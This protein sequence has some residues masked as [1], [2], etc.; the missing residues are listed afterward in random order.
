VA[1]ADESDASFMHLQPM[2]A[3]VTNIEATIT[4]ATLRRRLREACKQTFVD[5]LHNLPFY[6]LA[7]AVH[8][9]RTAWR[10]LLERIP[11]AVLTYGFSEQASTCAPV[12][13]PP[14]KAACH[15]LQ[16]EPA[17]RRRAAR[18]WC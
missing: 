9:R 15:A 12:E 8:R 2:L 1:E 4:W 14:A 6:G 5:F 13:L 17:R 3:V 7:I 18:R 16:G 10:A 11:R